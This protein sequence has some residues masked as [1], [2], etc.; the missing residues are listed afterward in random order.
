MFLLSPGNSASVCLYETI[1]T[2]VL[3][4]CT[5][6]TAKYTQKM[7]LRWYMY[8]KGTIYTK[9]AFLMARK[10]RIGAYVDRKPVSLTVVYI[11][12]QTNIAPNV[13]RTSTITPQ[14]ITK[15]AMD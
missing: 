3:S 11:V 4:N 15:F 10:V 13:I 9:G 14:Y 7:Y 6:F 12:A 2:A 8:E 5:H 1:F